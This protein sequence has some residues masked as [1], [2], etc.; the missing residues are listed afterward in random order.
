[1]ADTII[2]DVKVSN[3]EAVKEIE[4]S[5]AAVNALKKQEQE[6][7]EERVKGEVTAEDYY[8]RL[9][10]I[11]EETER[12]RQNMASYRKALKDNIK[13]EKEESDSL[14][15]MRKDLRLMLKEFDAMSRA[16]REGAKGQELLKHI[17]GLTK[18]IN[19]AEQ[20]S[21][22]FQRN[23]GN[24]GSAIE[25]LGGKLTDW[26]NKMGEAGKN[27]G[28]FTSSLGAMSRGAQGFG[29]TLK[30]L[31]TNP[32][33]IILR[34][35][36][37]L[38][39]ALR[40]QVQKSDDAMTSLQRLTAAFKP[41]MDGLRVAIEGVVKAFTAVVEWTSKAV[42]SLGKWLGL[43]RETVDANQD[44]VT[45]TDQL[46][47][48]ERDYARNSAKWNREASEAREKANDAENYTL[49]ERLDA[50]DV[51]SQAERKDL[52]ART[53]IVR[54]KIRLAKLEAQMQKDTSD[55]TKNRIADME[56]ELDN[57]VASAAM[58]E[59]SINRQRQTL[60]KQDRQA[61]A[62]RAKEAAQAA[63]E[64]R[65]A[66]LS[67]RQAVEDLMLAMMQ[68]GE[69]KQIAMQNQATERRVAELRRRL[70]EEKNL[71]AEAQRLIG[72]Q[73]I[74][75]EAQNQVAIG[76]IHDDALKARL[77]AEMEYEKR[78][79]EILKRQSE[80]SAQTRLQQYQ[81]ELNERLN[82]VRDN[83]VEI[84]KINEQEAQREVEVARQRVEELKALDEEI[85]ASYKSREEYELA[86]AEATG[87][88]IE[89][90]R[91]A[92]DASEATQ[93]AIQD[94]SKSV[95]D[96]EMSIASNFGA[97]A[98]NLSSIF[99]TLAKENDKYK[100]AAK[101]MA[102][103]QLLISSAVSIAK[104]VEGATIAAAS[105]GPAAPFTLAAYITEMVATVA[106]TIAQAKALF[107]EGASAFAEGGV[108]RGPGSGTSDS[109]TARVSN[110]EAIMTAKA[111]SMFYDQLSAMNVAGGGRPFDRRGGTAFASGGV[112]STRTL[113][114][115]RQMTAMAE[116][117]RD[118]VGEIQ[119]VVSVKEITRVQNRVKTKEMLSVS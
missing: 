79:A 10:A 4:Q 36:I 1:M 64:R 53:Q 70:T 18:E 101:A 58:A 68:E 87:K 41:V 62:Q 109:I 93:R 16:E 118:A 84:A 35:V 20:A 96:A 72:E 30:V 98:G 25:G 50:L 31:A 7:R 115:G 43:S 40:T 117:I 112:V 5:T 92:E 11:R 32:F 46:E 24:Y 88:V 75:I 100:D 45:S 107:A 71:T 65:Q 90:Q 49:K 12:H 55:E 51:A 74:L 108:V 22:R 38:F 44:L 61:R 27:G 56:A 33:F 86:L 60:I 110:G 97:I 42:Q 113:M 17:Q 78:S 26:A 39:T 21:G 69:E 119:P 28:I 6:L 48:A 102:L 111:T 91:A 81:N 57:L 103:M 29:Q 94:V 116:M 47:D 114:D 80:L 66:E 19:D 3:A 14:N 104:A 59:R 13:T 34:V 85:F 8:K 54:E 23:V 15:K 83:A 37:G 73:I 9:T 76:K 77:E 52:D 95:R 67:A 63:K 2:I 82:A 106:G 105:T 99:D 89:A